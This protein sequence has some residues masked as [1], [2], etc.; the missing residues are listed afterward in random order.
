MAQGPVGDALDRRVDDREERD[1]HGERDDDP[2]DDDE[3][4][5]VA[6][7]PEDREEHRAG[8]EPR[9]REH[10]AV[11]EVDQLEDPV[12]QRIAQG[13]DAV[14]GAAREA[15]EGDVDE[16][17]RPLDEVHDEPDADERHEPEPDA[18]DD[19]W[20]AEP[21]E[22]PVEHVPHGRARL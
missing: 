11:G 13:D 14:D 15:V 19:A 1:G 9:E 16:L 12:D 3:I 5:R 4:A 10:I 20:V 18:V 8:D 21:Y 17:L 2:S 22:N 7:Q 6:G